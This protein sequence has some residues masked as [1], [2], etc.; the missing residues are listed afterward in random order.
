MKNRTHKKELPLTPMIAEQMMAVVENGNIEKALKELKLKMK[1]AKIFLTLYQNA[2]YE[3]PSEKKRK[4]R[5]LAILREK[6]RK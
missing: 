5:H 6:Y 4:A 1:D 3:K 2:H